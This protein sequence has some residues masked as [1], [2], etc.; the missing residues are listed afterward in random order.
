MFRC[1][2]RL[3]IIDKRRQ[4]PFLVNLRRKLRVLRVLRVALRIID[5]FRIAMRV[6]L[7]DISRIYN[8]VIFLQYSIELPV[9]SSSRWKKR[10]AAN[11]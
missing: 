6:R 2:Y 9:K 8:A 3:S 7:Y 1:H 11:K 5:I 4:L 10:I